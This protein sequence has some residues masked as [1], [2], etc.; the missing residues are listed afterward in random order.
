M[1]KPIISPYVL[2]TDSSI[3]KI[4]DHQLVARYFD[5]DKTQK[6]IDNPG[7]WFSRYDTMSD[8][9]EGEYF[10]RYCASCQGFT[11]TELTKIQNA[12][13]SVH[14]P[15]ISCWT[16][17]SNGESPKMWRDY[18]KGSNG[19]CCVTEVGL[20]RESFV[21]ADIP[22]G[23]VSYYDVSQL[24]KRCHFDRIERPVF[25]VNDCG[26]HTYWSTE[27]VKRASFESEREFR[28]ICFANGGHLD[29]RTQ[30]GT[31]IRFA[32][33]QARPPFQKIIAGSSVS[34]G[35]INK[36]QHTFYCNVESSRFE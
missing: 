29:L 20:L 19:I 21:L 22:C 7:I 30:K 24:N 25:Y 2:K 23:K 3:F 4:P 9:R 33:L 36:L 12:S 27:F 6:L 8:D 18:A 15:L 13:R 32:D 16:D 10:E 14:M 1:N 17:F 28:F 11:T 34:Q 5:S 31:L 35:I 26:T